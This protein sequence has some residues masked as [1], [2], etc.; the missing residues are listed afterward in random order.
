MQHHPAQ[1]DVR[2]A[3]DVHQLLDV[4]EYVLVTQHAFLEEALQVRDQL[5]NLNSIN[6]LLVELQYSGGDVFLL[7]VHEQI[8]NDLIS[9]IHLYN[10][11][12]E[13]TYHTTVMY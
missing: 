10:K 2:L 13:H 7:H 9:Q 12:T 1:R 5:L 8:I 6:I 4:V 11:T 3:H